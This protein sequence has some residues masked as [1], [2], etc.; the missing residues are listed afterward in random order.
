MPRKSQRSSCRFAAIAKCCDC[1]LGKMGSEPTCGSAAKILKSRLIEC[2]LPPSWPGLFAHA[3][4]DR[5]PPILWKNNVLRTTYSEIWN[6][7]KPLGHHAFRVC[8]GAGKSLASFRRFWPTMSSAPH[9]VSLAPTSYPFPH[10]SGH[11]TLCGVRVASST[12]RCWPRVRRRSPRRSRAASTIQGSSRCC[13]TNSNRSPNG[14]WRCPLCRAESA[15]LSEGG[16]AV[17]FESVA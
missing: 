4:N 7:R 13:Q 5:N 17:G 16:G 8:R 10:H 6:E 14:R 2:R 11:L 3:A 15:P 9:V 1:S 12:T